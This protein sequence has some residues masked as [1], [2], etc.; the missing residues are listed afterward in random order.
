MHTSS[1]LAAALPPHLADTWLPSPS[2]CIGAYFNKYSIIA[3]QVRVSYGMNGVLMRNA[4]L[5]PLANFL[6]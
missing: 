3:M 5:L 1:R 4:D 6:W 2:K